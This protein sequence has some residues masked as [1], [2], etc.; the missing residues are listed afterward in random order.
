MWKSGNGRF[1]LRR[2]EAHPAV[3]AFPNPKQ[4]L[5]RG[6]LNGV[7]SALDIYCHQLLIC[8]GRGPIEEHYQVVDAHRQEAQCR[9]GGKP[10]AQRRGETYWERRADMNL[11]GYAW[12]WIM[13]DDLIMEV[14]EVRERWGQEALHRGWTKKAFEAQV[15]QLRVSGVEQT[16]GATA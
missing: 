4:D 11:K 6:G 8:A 5:R 15:V 14:T 13:R 7:A 16:E 12:N 9:C 1:C 10:A 3:I 2:G